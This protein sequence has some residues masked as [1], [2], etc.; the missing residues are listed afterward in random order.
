M[1]KNAR[2]FEKKEKSS[3][4]FPVLNEKRQKKVLTLNSYSTVA[5]QF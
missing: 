5:V 4:Y 1:V 2:E 3:P